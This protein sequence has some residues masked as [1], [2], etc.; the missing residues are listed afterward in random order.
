M[1]AL[2]VDLYPWIVALW[3][4]D[5]LVE[6]R[7]GHLLAVSGP[8]GARLLRAGLHLAGPSPLAEVIALHDLPWLPSPSGPHL[9]DPRR[10]PD[11]PLVVAADLERVEGAVA[12]GAERLG[13]RVVAGGRTVLVAPTPEWAERLRARLA[14]GVAGPADPGGQVAAARTRRARQRPFLGVLRVL[15]GLL[16]AGALLLWPL[17]AWL[18]DRVPASP[19]VLLAALAALVVAIAATGAAMLRACG[20][21][22]GASLRAALHLVVY[23]VAALRPLAHL[24]AS[25]YRDLEPAATL[26]AVLPR[27]ELAAFGGRELARARLSRATTPA[28]LGRAWDERIALLSRVLAAAGIPEAEATAPPVAAPGATAWCP[29]CRAQYLAGADACADC[30]VRTVPFGAGA[31]AAASRG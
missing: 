15:A 17:V 27:E 23:P 22:W 13:K 3:L 2:L 25:L 8:G 31:G 18:P 24:P 4:V 11:A 21:G 7:R 19:G 5:A 1:H 30:G 26:A 16:A 10:G 20:E 29:L 28:E 6:S 14:A 9:R 12:A